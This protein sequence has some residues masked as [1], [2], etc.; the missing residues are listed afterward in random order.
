MIKHELSCF[1]NPMNKRPCFDCKFLTKKET[2]VYYDLFDGEHQRKVELMYCTKFENF[3]YLPKN[4]IKKNIFELECD[5]NP[6]PD[7]CESYVYVHEV[8]SNIS[9]MFKNFK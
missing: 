9:E 8:D 1:K 3:M 6:M 7:L 4:A 2:I 5:N